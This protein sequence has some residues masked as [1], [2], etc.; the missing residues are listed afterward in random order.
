VQQDLKNYCHGGLEARSEAGGSR[1][2][3]YSAEVE[4]GFGS[5]LPMEGSRENAC[6]RV[7]R[8]C[9]T[10]SLEK[11]DTQR[12]GFL[13]IAHVGLRTAWPRRAEAMKTAGRENQKRC[14]SV[15]AS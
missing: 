5:Y 8:S 7:V 15:V 14:T 13:Q 9:S 3:G 6:G 4:I 1:G 11:L 2:T 12:S 10:A